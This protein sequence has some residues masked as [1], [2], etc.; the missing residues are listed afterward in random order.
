MIIQDRA[1]DDRPREKFERLG[2]NALSNAELLAILIGSG[3]TNENAIELMERILCGCEGNLNR[4]GRMSIPELCQYHGIGPAKAITILAACELG[5]RRE[6]EEI[7]PTT[8]KSSE[9][10]YKFF[11]P[12]IGESP[13]E[14]L[15]LLLMNN[16]LRVIKDVRLSIGGIDHAIADIRI[17]LKEALYANATYIALCHNHPSGNSRPSQADDKLTTRLKAAADVMQ[18]RMTDHIIVA[19]RTYYSYADE[20]KL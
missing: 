14:E 1:K 2:A 6:A 8:I 3:S 12:R 13:I 9:D 5:R 18:I 4:L 17:A 16:S 20:G 11:K 10:I 19:G 7:V 15:H